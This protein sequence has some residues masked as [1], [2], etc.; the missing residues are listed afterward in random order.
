MANNIFSELLSLSK[1]LA[2]WQNEAIR[3]MFAKSGSLPQKDRDEIF[4]IALVE[5]G[6][7]E[8]GCT[9]RRPDV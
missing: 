9:S 1:D 5:H 2:P 6:L 3:R 8:G 4:D 7:K